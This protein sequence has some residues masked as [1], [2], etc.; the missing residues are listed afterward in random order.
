MSQVC[1]IFAIKIGNMTISARHLLLFVLGLLVAPVA[2]GS[3]HH[4]APA[5]HHHAFRH[6]SLPMTADSARLHE[7]LKAFPVDTVALNE[8]VL[9]Q[10]LPLFAPLT[11]YRHPAQRLLG[12]ADSLDGEVAEAV[13]RVLLNIYLSRPD[14]VRNR[15][16]RMEKEPVRGLETPKVTQAHP[17]LVSKVAPTPAEPVVEPVRLVVQKPN[18]WSYGGDYYLQFLQNYVSGNWY[19]GGESNYS[20]LGSLTIQ[21]NYNNKQKVKW[22]NK[23]EMKLGFQTSRGDT[24]HRFKTSQDLL[25]YTTKLGLQA[26]RR[27]YYTAQLIA[28]T[29]FM[30]GYRSN[31]KFVYSD[32]LSPLNLNLSLGMDYQVDWL[33]N[34]VK[35]TIHL[36]PLAGNWRHVERTELVT[37]YGIDQGSHNLIDYG[38]EFTV[39]L[40]WKMNDMISW[41]TRLYGYTT[42]ERAELEWENTISFK[43]SRYISSNIFV[44]P[45]FD[46]GTRRDDHHGYWQFKEYTSIGFSYSF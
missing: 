39:D 27:W 9:Q 18:F 3:P 15:E 25:R 41:K 16:S 33:K 14:L 20:M 43:F 1:T 22:D 10:T 40:T 26:S 30:R 32:F 12:I 28:N 29:Q 7:R 6:D 13:D 38:S 37:R 31:D 24:L 8:E 23:L 4:H 21:A 5:V 34:T 42:Y 36:A 19:K 44:Y 17:D 35:G 46:D 2:W 11:F 45:R